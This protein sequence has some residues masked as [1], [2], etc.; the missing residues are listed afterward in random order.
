[1][2][3]REST[4]LSLQAIA[5]NK[6]RS[7]LTMLGIIIGVFAVIGMQ[8][9][10]QGL[11]NWWAQELSVMGADTFSIQKY[12]AVNI[13]GVDRYKNR[14]NITLEEAEELKE[15][16]TL[17]SGVSPMV[18][19]FGAVLR[20]KDKKTSP[21]MM[22]YG[23]DQ[24]FQDSNAQFVT[25]GRFLSEIDVAN[26]RQVC[27]IGLDI[28][29]ELFPFEDPLGKHLTI[30][31]NRCEVIG[32]LEKKGSIFG[33]SQDAYTVLPITTFNKFYGCNRSIMIGIRAKRP[34]LM[35][36]AMDEVIGIMRNIRRVPPGQPNDFE[37]MTSES[38]MDTW[39]DVTNVVF[40]VAL[41]I[42]GISLLVGGIGV[43]NIML[44]SV[45]ERTHEIGIRKAV[46][47][48]RNDILWQFLVEAVIICEFGGIIGVLLGVGVGLLIGAFTPLPAAVPLWA[49]LL[50]LGFISVVG[51]LFGLYPAAKASRLDPIVA[52]R[53]E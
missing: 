52:L 46:G 31:G 24:H 41:A 48:R 21:S 19:K 4:K 2:D 27:V 12:P 49:V 44:V 33:Q 1:M 45:T 13:G 50:G 25:E 23:S 7:I 38:L 29:E 16:A 40:I 30:D 3:I 32:I 22:I 28:V 20:Y 43:M 37:I 47:A 5:S 51:I 18:F 14:R 35:L 9:I 11:N 15:R 17:I 53:H 39:R 10:I 42:C 6:F 8:T 36:D 34:E 26:R